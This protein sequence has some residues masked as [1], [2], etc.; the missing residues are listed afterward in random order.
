[1]KLRLVSVSLWLSGFSSHKKR[2][3]LST[4]RVQTTRSV[5]WIPNI[6]DWLQIGILP[7]TKTDTALS[8]LLFRRATTSKASFL[9]VASFVYFTCSMVKV[10]SS[11]TASRCPSD[12]FYWQILTFLRKRTKVNLGPTNYRNGIEKTCYSRNLFIC[13]PLPAILRE[14]M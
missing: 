1:M 14:G 7:S 6:A 3:T 5:L 13:A 8:K 2:F 10:N 11:T 12:Y 4:F 9:F